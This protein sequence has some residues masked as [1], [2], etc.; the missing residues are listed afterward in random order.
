V[1]GGGREGGREAR[2]ARARAPR[3]PRPA[4]R[5][6]PRQLAR[7]LCDFADVRVAATAP[8]LS[9]FGDPDLPPA[10]RP[11]RGDA[12]EWRAWSRAGDPVLHID[13]RRWADVGLVAPLSANTLAKMAHVRGGRGRAGV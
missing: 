7:L 4:R 6:P 13:L 5:A 1:G 10:A 11:L 8:A 9:F 3:R 12:D 2:G